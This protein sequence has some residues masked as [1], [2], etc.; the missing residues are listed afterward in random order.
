[1]SED[2]H[3]P[4]PTEV[5]FTSPSGHATLERMDPPKTARILMCPPR[6]FA[7]DYVINPWMQGQTGHADASVAQRQWDGLKAA[8]ATR[9]NVD[10][11]APVAGLPDLVFTANAGL[12]FGDAFVPSR[13]RHAER[14]G[15]EPHNIAWFREHGFRVLELSAGI[16]FEGA[17]DALFDRAV[18]NRLWMGHGHRSDLRAAEELEKL[19]SVEALPLQLTDDRFYH[20]DTCFCPLRGGWLLYYQGAFD[21]TA[22]ALIEAKVPA[23]KR[24]AIE[25]SDA[26]HFACNAVDLGDAIAMNR[27]SDALKAKLAQAGFKVLE[28]PL[29]EFLKAG[30]AAKCLTLRLVEP[31]K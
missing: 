2:L 6:H 28:T 27:A 16:E 20:L 12:V 17:G 8:I 10:L 24:I 9:A 11:L 22:N 14:Q 7:V 21:A 30:G 19:L 26:V 23:D 29:G 31:L 1:M 15:E 25:E 5:G 4:R 18:P 3:A 13:F